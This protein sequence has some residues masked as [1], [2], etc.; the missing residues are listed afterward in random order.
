MFR[1]AGPVRRALAPVALCAGGLAVLLA[2]LPAAALQ[3]PGDARF[4]VEFSGLRAGELILRSRQSASAYAAAARLDSAGLVALFRPLRFEA[5]VQGSIRAGRLLPVAYVEDVDNGRRA[6]RTEL[7]Y[8]GGVPELRAGGP[9]PEEADAPWQIDP[10]SQAGTVDPMTAL[11]QVL[12]DVPP[13]AACR[14]DLAVYDG[15]R[16]GRLQLLDPVPEGDGLTCTG[17]YTRIAGYSDRDLAE[18][19]VFDVQ[20]RYAPGPNGA[21]RVVTVEADS[22]LGRARMRRN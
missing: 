8:V 12:A 14:L 2:A 18:R 5:E 6:A 1:R 20:L 17:R 7:A 21:L 13:A 22:P 15:R 3:L 10:A 16:R 9:K 4:A 19:R 11:L